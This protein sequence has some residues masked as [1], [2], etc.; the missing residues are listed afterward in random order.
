VPRWFAWVVCALG[1]I[2]IVTGWQLS[3][4]GRE[5]GSYT[6]TRGRIVRAQVEETPRPSEE[7]GPQ[8]TPAVRYAFEAHGR[9]YES[10]LVSVAS[11]TGA[12][13]SDA[14]EARRVV[15]RYPPGSEVDVWFDPR[16]P[17]RSVLVRGVARFQV[18]LAVAI[19]VVLLGIGMFALA[20]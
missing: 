19:G 10:D 11:G 15:E 6:R 7:G 16:D 17:R 2:L 20:R 9:T 12:G 14:D 13:T 18:V 1:T 4:R 8:F 5:T 3:R